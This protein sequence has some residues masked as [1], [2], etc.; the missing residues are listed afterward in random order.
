VLYRSSKTISTM[1]KNVS[2]K[3]KVD[4]ISV[5]RKNQILDVCKNNN[6]RV[7]KIIDKPNHYLV[8]FPSSDDA[9]RI[10]DAALAHLF[11]AANVEPVMPNELKAGRTIIVKR[12]D[13]IIFS[14]SEDEIK[15]SVENENAGTVITEIHKFK[16]SPGIK[17]IFSNTVMAEKSLRNGFFAFRLF[18]PPNS[19][20]RDE[21][22]HIQTCY[23]CY[24]I[25]NHSTPSCPSVQENPEYKICS[26]CSS[27]NHTWKQCQ[28]TR[29][30]CSNCGGE[31]SALSYLCK[32]RQDAIKNKRNN[33]TLPKPT[34]A[35][36]SSGQSVLST[37][38]N[39]NV[40]SKATTCILLAIMKPQ[41]NPKQFED[42][43]NHLLKQNNLPTISIGNYIPPTPSAI[44]SST[45]HDTTM[46]ENMKTSNVSSMPSNH[47]NETLNSSQSKQR[48]LPTTSDP[49]QNETKH[50]KL[51]QQPSA[52]V[53]STSTSASSK[54]KSVTTSRNTKDSLKTAKIFRNYLPI[55]TGEELSE[56]IG[57]GTA[58]IVDKNNKYLPPDQIAEI[59][60]HFDEYR[61]KIE[62]LKVEE[63]KKLKGSISEA[64]QII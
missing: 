42:T 62:S 55:R 60:L 61:N 48:K 5:S 9:D 27:S 31:H 35:A 20:Q 22:I 21:F 15:S 1:T 64:S 37:L 41:Q 32:V 63:L 10:F 7:I 26:L 53:P 49:P 8:I 59:C 33:K 52:S 28:E 58:V 51:T 54:A 25:E 50:S 38:P 46:H 45:P 12:I 24:K 14:A 36:V 34:Y 11:A 57:R 39:I 23:R 40:T 4:L 56:S 29:R 2:V 47:K 16:N 3:F 17:V 30:S 6:I 43:L 44:C 13:E 18:I 19:I